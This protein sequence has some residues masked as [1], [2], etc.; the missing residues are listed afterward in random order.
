MKYALIGLLTLTFCSARAQDSTRTALKPALEA[1]ERGQL[2]S[3]FALVD[4]VVIEHPTMEAAYKLR[5]DIHQR[6]QHYEEA[7][8]DYD[9]AEDLDRTDARLYVSRSALRIAVGN[10]K[11]AL[12]DT[13]KAIELDATDADAWYNRAWAQYLAND[14]DAALK[15]VKTAGQLRPDFPEALYL[16]GVIKGEQYNEKDGIAEITEALRLKPTIPGGL[17]SKAV[18]QYEGKDYEAA[19]A[20]LTEVI[21]TDDTELAHAYYY[22]ADCHYELG[23]KELACADF[24]RS[25]GLGDKDAAFIKR[26]Y[27]DTDAKRIPK[28]PKKAKRKTSIQF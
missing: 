6:K 19:I 1:Y 16:S 2:D 8:A 25:M 13:Q 21:A 4:R 28:K 20:T 7:A 10:E 22:R 9:K 18:L 11:G 26:T 5:G 14:G 24:N 23:N 17:M 3:A 12:R 15:S 27:C